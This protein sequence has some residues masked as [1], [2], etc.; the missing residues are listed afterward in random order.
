MPATD[1]AELVLRGTASETDISTVQAVLN[2]MVA[3]ADYYSLPG[4]REALRARIAA[5]LAGLLREAE[6]GSDHQLAYTRTLLAVLDTEAGIE[7][8]G[9]WLVDEE[10]PPGLAVDA[11]LRWRVLNELSRLGAVGPAELDAE[12]ERDPSVTGREHRD[13]ARSANPARELKEWAW[14][15]ATVT[16]DLTNESHNKVCTHFWKFG[17]DEV[18]R[19][20]VQRYLDVVGEIAAEAGPWR[21]ASPQHRNNVVGL[22]FPRPFAD[23]E[24]I[25]TLDAWLADHEVPSHVHRILIEKRDDSVRALR[26]QGRWQR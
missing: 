1:Y 18:L 7:L 26:A 23:V 21:G 16:L 12:S 25:D 2:N 20:Y 9:G 19:P 22:L 17:Q 11:D 14:H 4:T 3:A 10:V 24:F 13:G 15:T 8:I 5:G 6:P